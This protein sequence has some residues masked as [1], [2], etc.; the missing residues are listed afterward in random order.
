MRITIDCRPT[1]TLASLDTG[2][3]RTKL[4]IL[5]RPTVCKIR[6]GTFFYFI[7]LTSAVLCLWMFV[8]KISLILLWCNLLARILG[9]GLWRFWEIFVFF[10][11]SILL[12]HC[13]IQDY[14]T[15][16]SMQNNVSA[17]KLDKQ[18]SR[19]DNLSIYLFILILEILL[20]NPINW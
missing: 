12:Y 5:P 13:A 11:N 3:Y 8:I 7:K 6:I 4:P 1:R 18:I 19:L 20:D 10:L 14:I 9:K 16:W 2:V 17:V 15:L